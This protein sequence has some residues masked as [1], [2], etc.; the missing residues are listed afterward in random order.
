MQPLTF[1]GDYPADK[2]HKDEYE[3][4][5]RATL[6]AIERVLTRGTDDVFKPPTFSKSIESI[7]LSE[8]QE[9]FRKIAKSKTIAFLKAA[10]LT[11]ERIGPTQRGLVSKDENSFLQC[12]WLDPFDAVKYL[13]LTCLHFEKIEARRIPKEDRIVHSHRLSNIAGELFDKNFGYDSFREQSSALS[14]ERIGEWKIVTDIAN[15]F[16][17]IGNHSLENHLLNAGCEKRYT[18]LTRDILLFWAGDRRSFGVPVGSDASRILSEAVLLNVD[19]KLRDSNITFIRYV[20]DFRIFAKTRASALKAVQTL[21]DLLSDEGL[22]LNSKKT[23][24]YRIADADEIAQVAN[25]FAGGEHELINLDEKIEVVRAIRVSGRSSVSRF[26]REP[27][28]DTLKKIQAMSKHEII[29]SFNE[30]SDFDIE[31]QIKL[32]VKYFVYA[33]QDV[34]L[35]ARLI[36]RKITSIYYIV[37]ALIKEVGKFSPEKCDE[38]KLSVF[39]AVE[40]LSCAYPLQV[41]ILRLSGSASFSDPRFVYSIVDNHRHS[42]NMLFYREAISLGSSCLDRA[43]LRRLAMEIFQNVPVLVRRAIYH[44]IKNHGALSEDEKRPLIRNMRQH[45]DDWFISRL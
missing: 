30:A 20:D 18:D 13:A 29:K 25:H 19:E 2:V 16:D 15:F 27:G 8:G 21:T 3:P 10:D 22:S 43:R 42:D 5:E 23:E 40:W 39:E 17:R 32:V 44:A 33:D 26:Y 41:P 36:D 1:G 34:T 11:K 45:E 35:L 14:R 37:D 28:K 6:L 38:I 24:I 31:Q 9:E 4:I 7:V 12:A